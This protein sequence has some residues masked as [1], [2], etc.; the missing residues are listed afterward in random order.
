MHS[1]QSTIM[2]CICDGQIDIKE[3]Y[4][5]KF[6]LRYELKNLIHC[7]M[8]DLYLNYTHDLKYEYLS[9]YQCKLVDMVFLN[10]TTSMSMCLFLNQLRRTFELLSNLSNTNLKATKQHKTRNESSQYF[11]FHNGHYSVHIKFYMQIFEYIKPTKG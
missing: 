10:R 5:S 1:V 8:K 3:F 4:T 2:I 11:L 7:C 6:L 9:T